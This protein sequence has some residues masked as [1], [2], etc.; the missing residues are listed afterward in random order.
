M[1]RSIQETAWLK[2]G[3]ISDV[4]KKVYAR[5][6]EAFAGML[7]H[8]DAQIGRLTDYLEKIGQLEH[9]VIVLLSDNGATSE[10]GPS[11]RLNMNNGGNTVTITDT[12]EE[13]LAQIDL[14]GSEYTQN[15]YPSGWSNLGNTPFQWYKTWSHAGGVKDPLIISYP[16][17]IK[18]RGSIR[19]QYHHVIDITPTIL[20][21]IGVEKP[22]IIKGIPQKPFHGT[23]MKYSFDNPNAED[24]HTIQYFEM[25]GNRAIYKDGWRAVVNHTFN[26]S[27]DEDVWELYHVAEDFSESRDVA[28]E[29]P[30]K[31][32]EL[33]EDWLI[34]AGKYGVFPMH[35]AS[36]S[37]GG[38][39]YDLGQKISFPERQYEYH[40]IDQ[41]FELVDKPLL[42]GNSFSLRFDIERVSADEDGVLY[43]FGDRFGGFSLYIKD[44]HLK[45]AFSHSG[46]KLTT[47]QT[48]QE[49]PIQKTVI[50]LNVRR[51]GETDALV[52]LYVNGAKAEEVLLRDYISVELMGN[53]YHV[54][55]A[56]RQVTVTD[57]YSGPFI[58]KGNI[59]YARIRSAET[60]ISSEKILDDFFNVD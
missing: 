15:S 41:Y 19:S 5:Y 25:L 33:K 10:G 38:K 53:M 18:A 58:F 49:L 1:Q 36:C 2:R 20:D 16:E 12:P 50:K 21:I 34:E 28:S 30:K 22:A 26:E 51:W 52:S 6:M 3:M 43:S 31:I 29:Y 48:G 17:G 56:D 40:Y 14:I 44:N 27:F 47:I 32:Q 42:Y 9:T 37:R 23:S 39:S 45:F 54:I 59:V 8:T 60:Q 13:A 7:E 4:Q 35:N 57:D 46:K 24:T 11:G 55:G